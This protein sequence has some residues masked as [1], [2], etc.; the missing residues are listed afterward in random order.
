MDTNPDAP[1]RLQF[2]TAVESKEI[3]AEAAERG[4]VTCAACRR[5]ITDEYFDVNGA[6]VCESCHHEIGRHAETPRGM[7]IFVKATIFGVVWGLGAAVS[8]G[9]SIR[10]PPRRSG[11]RSPS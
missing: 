2:E 3:A 10:S 1:L 7:G 9:S 4:Q 6:T 5:A 8:P 11:S